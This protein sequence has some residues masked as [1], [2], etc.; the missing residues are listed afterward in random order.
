MINSVNNV[1][2]YD[3]KFSMMIK[4]PEE[5]NKMSDIFQT[6]T[7]F[8]VCVCCLLATLFPSITAGS[9]GR[10]DMA[11]RQ[12]VQLI[13]RTDKNSKLDSQ[14]TSVRERFGRRNKSS[15]KSGAPGNSRRRPSRE[16]RKAL[17]Q[18]RAAKE[19]T[20]NSR[21]QWKNT[22]AV[23]KSSG[24]QVTASSL[25]IVA[26]DIAAGKSILTSKSG[27]AGKDD[28][29]MLHLDFRDTDL[30]TIINFL[31]EQTQTNYLYDENLR[32]KI[33]LIGP[34]KVP[35]EEAVWLLE[36][37]LEFKG[38]T[39]VKVGDFK[40]VIPLAKAQGDKI[41]TR[42]RYEETD[43]NELSE[44]KEVTQLI[45]LKHTNAADIKT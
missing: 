31:S 43:V 24:P 25:T 40:K 39:V 1:H 16:E 33:T 3:D 23:S 9:V 4:K 36:S 30:K 42:L 11:G 45:K 21:N 29:N 6:K 41:E 17:R 8:A 28:E 12:L 27:L 14:F 37:L 38:Y 44:N 5:T 26:N 2:K 19:R 13:E 20:N 10:T 34:K 32:G 7:I 18:N 22:S 15:R 35:V